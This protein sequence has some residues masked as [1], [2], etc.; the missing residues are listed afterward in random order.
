MNLRDEI[1]SRLEHAERQATNDK[2]N[3]AQADRFWIGAAHVLRELL[4]F[5]KPPEGPTPLGGRSG[6]PAP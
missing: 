4:E 1:K 5:V 3:G 6:K 2:W